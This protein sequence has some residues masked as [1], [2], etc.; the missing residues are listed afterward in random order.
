MSSQLERLVNRPDIHIAENAQGRA[1][2]LGKLAEDLDLIWQREKAKGRGRSFL[3]SLLDECTRI[4]STLPEPLTTRGEIVYHRQQPSFVEAVQETAKRLIVVDNITANLPE[5]VVGVICGGSLSY[6]R[7]YNVRCQP[8]PSDIDLFYIVN[9]DFFDSDGSDTSATISPNRGFGK[10]SCEDFLARSVAFRR[11]FTQG[12]AQLISLKVP[13]EDFLVS[14]KIMPVKTFVD[15]FDTELKNVIEQDQKTIVPVYDFKQGPYANTVFIQYNFLHEPYYFHITE[16]YPPEGGA[17]TSI[18]CVFIVDG[19][20]YTG[21]HHNHVT[22]LFEVEQDKSGLITATILQFK[23]H[24]NQRLQLERQRERDSM[25]EFV[26]CH[27]RRDI[28]SPRIVE[29]A[30]KTMT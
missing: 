16:E 2:I 5:S 21:Q 6:G 28:L 25:L 4:E 30:R 15:E 22:P 17:I 19:H 13:V 20:L 27:D 11:L 8:N 26:N 10:A 29:R 9:Q 23:R 12:K 3:G 7:F 1:E 24:L 18:P 14:I